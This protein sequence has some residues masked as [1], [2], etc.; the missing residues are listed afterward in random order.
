M[1]KTR[2]YEIQGRSLETQQLVG[3]YA[4]NQKKLFPCVAV[5]V[6]DNA[7]KKIKQSKSN[8]IIM[9]GAYVRCVVR[10]QLSKLLVSFG[11]TTPKVQISSPLPLPCTHAR[12]FTL[13]SVMFIVHFPPPSPLTGGAGAVQREKYL[14][15]VSRE[16]SIIQL[17]DVTK[18]DHA[19]TAHY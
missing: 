10:N 8:L 16:V 5:S 3:S 15:D 9:T 4:K 14:C 19:H 6:H 1:R 17:H 2:F 13:F 11:I 12:L 7:M 18:L